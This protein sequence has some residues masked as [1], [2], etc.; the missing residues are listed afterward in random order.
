MIDNLVVN[1]EGFRRQVAISGDST[2]FKRTY[3][4]PNAN[5]LAIGYLLERLETSYPEA[6][7]AVEVAS[8][9]DAYLKIVA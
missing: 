9:E 6:L 5:K 2:D 4:I 8:L 1:F 3:F 7:L